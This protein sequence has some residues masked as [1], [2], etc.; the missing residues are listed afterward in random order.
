MSHI[1]HKFIYLAGPYSQGDTAVNVAN[2][3]GVAN[4]LLSEG[5]A[6]YVPHLTHFWHMLH[7]RDYEDWMSLD[8]DWLVKCDTILRM[9]GDSP[10]SDREVEIAIREQM[11]V[12]YGRHG[13]NELLV[14][15]VE[16]RRPKPNALHDE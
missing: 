13:L 10:G 11:P 6:P 1:L 16:G 3:L 12:F 4:L 2:A 8:I 7:H 5:Y 15:S 9:P 14:A